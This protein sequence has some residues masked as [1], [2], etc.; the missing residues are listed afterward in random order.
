[1]AGAA[2]P[3]GVLHG[4]RVL[5]LARSAA[6]QLAARQLAESGAEVARLAAAGG[7]A[8]AVRQRSKAVLDLDPEAPQDRARL[9]DLLAGAD[10]L[11]H[12][13]G[14]SHAAALGLDDATLTGRFAQLVVCAV[15]AFP[16]AGPEADGPC[17][18]SLVLARAGML[19]EFTGL[20]RTEGPV[21]VRAPFATL[22][23]ARLALIGVLARLIARRR[24]G[25][26]GTV[27]TS[28]LQGALA[29]MGCVWARAEAPAFAY[30]SRTLSRRGPAE[31]GFG[32]PRY[33]CA[34]GLWMQV[35]GVADFL[36]LMAEALRELG[37]TPP[38]PPDRPVRGAGLG[39]VGLPEPLKAR[40]F[41]RRPRAAW[42]EALWGADVPAFPCLELGEI[43]ADAQARVNGFSVRV[44]DP[45]GG[46]S[47][48][49]GAPYLTAPPS[50]IR[51][52]PPGPPDWPPRPPAEVA[53]GPARPPLDG[54]RV[55]DLGQY[56]AGPFL[57]MILAD[58]GA[59]VIKL[60]PV[61]GDGLRPP[62][63][64]F[65][66]PAKSF[67]SG[68]RGKRALAIDLKAPEAR[69]VVDALAA[70][71]DVVCHNVRLGA[72][73]RLGLD[74]E[75]L[76]ADRPELV[77]CHI[78]AYGAKGPRA[79]WPG[80]DPLAQAASG[81]Q[82][83]AAGEGNPPMWMRNAYMDY[84]CGLQAAAAAL[85]AIH[86][87][88]ATGRGQFCG[89]SLLGECLQSI[90]EVT[91]DDAGNVTP[92]PRLDA[93]QTGLSPFDRLYRCEDGRWLAL[94][95]RTPAE[96]AGLL[97]AFDAAAPEALEAAVAAW[98]RE[99][100]L[101][102]LR[103]AG[104]PAEPARQDQM[105]AFFDS[106]EARAQGLVAAYD[107]RDWGRLE[108]VGALWDFGDLP[109]RLDRPPPALGEN[110]AGVC[111]ELGVD[112]TL[113]ARLLERGSLK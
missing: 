91:M 44:E 16:G 80:F 14:P 93:A 27:R 39:H 77:Y 5:D 102:R 50:R 96:R 82:M 58:L 79:D 63:S 37:E 32:N 15:T 95:A 107:S 53:R 18:D 104:V 66:R 19:D 97:A 69:P 1:V 13:Y 54:V 38:A 47:W 67:A 60:E 52:P 43:Y 9:L 56:I 81:W 90:G 113:T 2:E 35:I 106:A 28:L 48:Q 89:A 87:R 20:S 71:A 51:T 12:D 41:A 78:D 49:P 76:S 92:R 22:G 6:G 24:D 70:W 108:Q 103:D 62:A 72:V 17:A 75:T 110:T 8:A 29:S 73:R 65:W 101:A 64:G 99:Y 98:P 83:E 21:Y 112:P 7:D 85:L 68:N 88:Q 26:G 55:L 94:L 23:A 59:E 84:H 40:A 105:D 111:A 57:A 3:A 36:P 33:R 25:R 11:I 34:D 4:L 86:H 30:M 46:A 74:Y 45:A 42:L 61:G 109:L 31:G 100:V 10:V